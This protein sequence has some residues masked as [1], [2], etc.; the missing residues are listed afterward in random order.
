MGK[1]S[2]LDRM[3]KVSLFSLFP[4]GACLV[5]FLLSVSNMTD[6]DIF[7]FTLNLELLINR[8]GKQAA[9]FRA[10]VSCQRI[11]LMYFRHRSFF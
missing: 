2:R 9:D 4:K 1:A 3:G 10:G 7:G 8:Y 11:L 5:S 6:P